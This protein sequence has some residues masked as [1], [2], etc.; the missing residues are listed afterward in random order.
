MPNLD[1]RAG[2]AF[3][4][5]LLL[6]GSPTL[7]RL[8]QTEDRSVLSI[9]GV[10]LEAQRHRDLWAIRA[11]DGVPALSL[12]TLRS[13]DFVELVVLDEAVNL[14]A[15]IEAPTHSPSA[16]LR[17]AQDAVVAIGRRDQE[18]GL[19][20]IDPAGRSLCFA[21]TVHRAGTIEV[22][23]TE[24]GLQA[25]LRLLLALMVAV[26]AEPAS[27]TGRHDGHRSEPRPQ[28]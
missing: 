21:G 20:V 1:D 6:R 17:D 11:G 15:T 25:P 19:Q 23:L 2:C 8:V 18:G 26:L 27:G 4:G 3:C 7:G 12:V 22:L 9:E 16:V 28:P 5:G 13:H 14:I 10:V 24:L